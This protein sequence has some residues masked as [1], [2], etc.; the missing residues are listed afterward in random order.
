MDTEANKLI[1]ARLMNWG[2]WSRGGMPALG[3]PAWYEVMHDYFPS[4][5]RL[6]PDSND[7]EHIEYILSSL[8]LGA[9][10]GIGLGDLYLFICK[11][12]YKEIERPRESKAEHVR[13]KYQLPCSE[14]TFRYHLHGAKKAVYL[15][16]N[17]I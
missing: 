4:A 12:E 7:A 2:L 10:K 11:L 3:Y 8:N 13:R 15:L 16:A 1:T 6:S 9:L 14:R 17:P 5:I